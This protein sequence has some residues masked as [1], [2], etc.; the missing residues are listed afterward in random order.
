[1]KIESREYSRYVSYLLIVLS[2]FLLGQETASAQDPPPT[3]PVSAGAMSDSTLVCAA[4]QQS[5]SSDTSPECLQKL[6]E[7]DAFPRYQVTF[8]I[9]PEDLVGITEFVQTFLQ[10]VVGY[11][12]DPGATQAEL[13]PYAFADAVQH[14][15]VLEGAASGAG[16]LNTCFA[17]SD[18]IP[19]AE[20]PTYAFVRSGKAVQAV[21]VPVH[22]TELLTVPPRLLDKT[23][24]TFAVPIQEGAWMPDFAS[25]E[26][27]HDL[28][29][30]ALLLAGVFPDDFTLTCGASYFSY[31]YKDEMDPVERVLSLYPAGSSIVV[32]RSAAGDITDKLQAWATKYGLTILIIDSAGN[33]GVPILRDEAEKNHVLVLASV[34][35]N[36]DLLAASTNVCTQANDHCVVENGELDLSIGTEQLQDT[37]TSFAAPRSAR[38]YLRNA[39]A[40][41]DAGAPALTLHEFI[42]LYY[43]V[44][45]Y[46]NMIEAGSGSTESVV[47]ELPLDTDVVAALFGST[48]PQ[49]ISDNLILELVN[50][51]WPQQNLYATG[52][53][54][55]NVHELAAGEHTLTS[56]ASI[57]DLIRGPLVLH[58]SYRKEGDP[59]GTFSKK[60]LS[61]N[62]T[63]G[64]RNRLARTSAVQNLATTTVTSHFSLRRV[65]AG[66]RLDPTADPASDTSR[67]LTTLFLPVVTR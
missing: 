60:T 28:G 13:R 67:E 6:I 64:E 48:P 52:L 11:F 31:E 27:T 35:G 50:E 59:E 17:D 8:P 12:V 51:H 1:M 55:V 58:V 41:R 18:Q 16:H 44:P 66:W 45:V 40:R 54:G 14:I 47:F 2:L 36:S 49:F 4:D 24:A 5:P 7:Q 25:T 43:N 3:A 62:G 39:Q 32:E 37:G 34:E 65:Q 56:E 61:V 30:V 22:L 63:A 29:V 46:G 20:Q 21:T 15:L 19:L 9:R 38:N 33:D 42:R 57:V 10:P 26:D 53:H 23:S